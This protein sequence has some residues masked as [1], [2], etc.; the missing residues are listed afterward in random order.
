M[1]F[2]EALAALCSPVSCKVSLIFSL[3]LRIRKTDLVLC[4]N[5]LFWG[6]QFGKS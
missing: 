3:I 2:S 5:D 1:K 4:L 6:L